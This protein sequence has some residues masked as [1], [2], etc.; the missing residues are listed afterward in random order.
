MTGFNDLLPPALTDVRQ[1]KLC[2]VKVFENRRS[3]RMR[4]DTVRIHV[5]NIDDDSKPK[6]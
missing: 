4:P 6:R 3:A 1:G 2:Q 5:M